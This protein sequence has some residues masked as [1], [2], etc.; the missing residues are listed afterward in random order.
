MRKVL[1]ATTALIAVGT[2]QAASADVTISGSY[3]WQY[4][5]LDHIIQVVWCA[6]HT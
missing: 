4:M 6:K 5:R 2:V 3:E 1:L